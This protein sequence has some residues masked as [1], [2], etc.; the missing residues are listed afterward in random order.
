METTQS[1]PPA[2]AT[3]PGN[4]SFEE[5]LAYLAEENT[6]AFV[7]LPVF[8]DDGEATGARV[9]VLFRDS[10]GIKL[11]YAAGPL[12]M[13]AFFEDEIMPL[14]DIPEKATALRYIPTIYQDEFFHTSLQNAIQALMK[15]ARAL[16]D[17]TAPQQK[18]V[19]PLHPI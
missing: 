15:G 2:A 8:E 7:S 4:L 10:D 1:A 16:V 6:A 3:A 18:K 9:L 17:G 12:F 13:L 5:T 11:R 14:A 19:I